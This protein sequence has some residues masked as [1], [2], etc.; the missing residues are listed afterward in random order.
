MLFAQEEFIYK[1]YRSASSSTNR[2]WWFFFRTLGTTRTNYR[3]A[4]APID[5]Q[6]RNCGSINLWGC[7]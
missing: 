3:L 6:V 2:G 4:G 5:P 1:A 7:L